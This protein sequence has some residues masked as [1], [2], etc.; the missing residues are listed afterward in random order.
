VQNWKHTFWRVTD[1]ERALDLGIIFLIPIV[2]LLNNEN[3]LY[4]EIGWTDPWSYLSHFLFYDSQT[5]MDYKAARFP[6]VWSGFAA[7]RLFSP[8]IAIVVLS[9]SYFYLA[10]FS[11]YLIL[12]CL[13]SGRAAFVTTVLLSCYM[14]F[15][16][17]YGWLYH[18]MAATAF[19]LFSL[20]LFLHAAT[21]GTKRQ[22]VWLFSGGGMLLLSLCTNMTYLPFAPIP[23]VFFFFIHFRDTPLTRRQT[24]FRTWRQ[25]FWIISGGVLTALL[26]THIHGAAGHIT[27]SSISGGVI[28]RTLGLAAIASTLG[29]APETIK[30][31]FF[32]GQLEYAIS[33]QEWAA[34]QIAAGEREIIPFKH[35]IKKAFLAMPVVFLLFS[36]TRLVTLVVTK[37]ESRETRNATFLK[38]HIPEILVHIQLVVMCVVFFLVYRKG[39]PVLW[40]SYTIFPV[41]S[42]VFMAV[43][44]FIFHFGGAL[45]LVSGFVVRAGTLALVLLPLLLTYHWNWTSGIVIR[46]WGVFIV[47]LTLSIGSIICAIYYRNKVIPVFTS[48]F[49]LS[50]VN[51][52]CVKS[53]GYISHYIGEHNNKCY[54]K[55]DLFMTAY[56]GIRFLNTIESNIS[57][58]IYT[59]DYNDALDISTDRCMRPLPPHLIYLLSTSISVA[60]VEWGNNRSWLENDYVK[61]PFASAEDF[62]SQL[63][64]GD[65]VVIISGRNSAGKRREQIVSAAAK[66]GRTMEIL[67]HKSIKR[68]DVAIEIDVMATP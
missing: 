30:I 50:M 23:L 68:N 31:P 54:P 12:A 20:L 61:G 19:Y 24:L 57:T 26:I 25:L 32:L 4:T 40:E 15:H 41:I 58:F 11:F 67:A 27:Y 36:A 6:W 52:L 17:S 13:F 59:Y 39:G 55:K 35:I 60:R 2:L 51:I 62:A 7:Y 65:R 37:F 44:A 48:V 28:A 9:L 34:G 46:N 3:W 18:N 43:G 63:R 10:L 21:V 49:L 22:S 14:E 66:T 38:R 45:R 64:D 1:R 47:P 5:L 16:G 42:S 33:F 29:F 53:P 56:D 8:E